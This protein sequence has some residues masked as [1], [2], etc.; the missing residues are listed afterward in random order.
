PLQSNRKC[1]APATTVLFVRKDEGERAANTPPRNIP[2][3][4][5]YADLIKPGTIAV[6]SQPIGARTATMGGLMAMRISKLGAVGVVV[7]GRVRDVKQLREL[8]AMPVWCKST[9][10]VATSGECR[11]HAINVPIRVG[12]TEVKPGDFIILD[13]EENGAVCIPQDRVAAVLQMIP[14]M[15]AKDEMKMANV[16]AGMSVV[17]AVSQA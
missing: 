6:L 8:V 14:E 12:A 7:D 9:S 11:A 1:I 15:A 16:V 13:P 17:E 2:D 4:S 5:V 3:D 10:I